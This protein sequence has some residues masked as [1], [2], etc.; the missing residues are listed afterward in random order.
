[1]YDEIVMQ[2]MYKMYRPLWRRR[3]EESDSVWS[4]AATVVDS[5]NKI[6]KAHS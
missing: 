4:L 1:M 5:A 2:E 6:C 3:Q